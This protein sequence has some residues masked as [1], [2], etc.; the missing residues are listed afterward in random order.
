M[1]KNV[2]IAA[3]VVVILVVAGFML[4]KGNPAPAPDASPTEIRLDKP[5]SQAGETKPEDA[6][7]ET[8]VVVSYTDSGFSPKAVTVKKN[9]KVT[10]LNQSAKKMWVASAV[11]PTHQEYPGFDQLKSV[12]KGEKYE[13]VFTKVGNWKYH[14]HVNPS[15]FGSV[16]VTE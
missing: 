12:G 4:M 7:M 13:F 11:H 5:A 10:F 2:L 9:T 1:N 6:L 14:N 16:E 15:D 3:V 8:E